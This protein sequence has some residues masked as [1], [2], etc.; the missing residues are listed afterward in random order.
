MKPGLTLALPAFTLLTFTF[1]TVTLTFLALLR[2][3]L[4]CFCLDKFNFLFM[5]HFVQL[6]IHI[7][8]KRAGGYDDLESEVIDSCLVQINIV[9]LTYVM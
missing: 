3:D 8:D 9:N 6:G 1:L 7:V 5:S 4:V 2:D